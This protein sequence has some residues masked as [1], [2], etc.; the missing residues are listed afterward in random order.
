MR[1]TAVR[2]H[3]RDRR[4]SWPTPWTGSASVWRPTPT[5]WRRWRPTARDRGARS[6]G[7]GPWP[8]TPGRG[9]RRPSAERG[10]IGP[11][12]DP[13][14]RDHARDDANQ[15]G[16]LAARP[17]TDRKGAHP[18]DQLGLVELGD[19][20]GPTM[21]H[22]APAGVLGRIR[23]VDLEGDRYALGRRQLR[24]G[25]RGEHDGVAVDDVV[26]RQD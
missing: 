3:A 16:T 8:A 22:D 4:R 18:P 12:A 9:G 10:P 2:V 14:A 20:F 19:L 11:G 21:E 7:A 1:C 24:T 6:G 15:M 5:P 23:P 13:P 26:D 25:G 17:G